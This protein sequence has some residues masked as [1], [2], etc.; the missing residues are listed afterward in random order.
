MSG[1]AALSAAKRRRGGSEPSSSSTS[2]EPR[3]PGKPTQVPLSP[4]QI[5]SQHHNKLDLLYKRQDRINKS[6]NITDDSESDTNIVDRLDNV[7]R[8]LN[9]DVGKPISG[10]DDAISQVNTYDEQIKELKDIILKVQSHSIE[11]SLELALLKKKIQV[12]Q[13]TPEDAVEDVSDDAVE[14]VVDTE[15]DNKDVIGG[16]EF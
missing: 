11:V 14:D 9:I 6:L 16:E 1:S 12:S 13:N 15:S 3:N 5:L 2:S 4:L 10:I 7:E 8:Q